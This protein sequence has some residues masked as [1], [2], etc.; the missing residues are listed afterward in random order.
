MTS[1]DRVMKL[2][3]PKTLLALLVGAVTM[4]LPAAAQAASCPDLP[5]PQLVT[6]QA[7]GQEQSCVIPPGVGLVRVMA[8]GGTG[9]SD[10]AAP[11][12]LGAVVS[13]S[14]LLLAVSFT[15][16]GGQTNTITKRGVHV[17]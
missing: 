2:Q 7:A 6:F 16:P 9:G 15:P 11:G 5:G 10:P 14:M 13:G 4:V 12:G 8:V 3:R 17:G 1:G